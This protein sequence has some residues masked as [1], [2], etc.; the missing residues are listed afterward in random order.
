[1]MADRLPP[2]KARILVCVGPSPACADLIRAA[3]NLATELQ[4]EWF[5][6]Y[7][8][9][10][11]MLRLPEAE[12]NRA[13]YNLR[14]AEQLGAE[15]IT[16]R[17]IRIAA[18]IVNFA[19]RRHITKIVAGKPRGRRWRDF[20]SKS[21]VDELVRLS[22]E[23]DVYVTTGEPGE[24]KEAPVLVQPK[25]IRLPDYEVGLIYVTLATGLCFLMYPYFDLPNLIMVYLLAVMVTAVQ[26]GRGPAI[27][28]ALLSVLAFD[29]CFVPPRWS[30][31]V[32]D[33]KYLVTFVV[34]FL[35]AVVIGHLASLIRRQAE[36]ARL[37]ERQ[38]AAMQALSQQLAGSRGVEKILQVAVQ[39]ISE[40]LGCQVVA[41]LP[42][43]KGRLHVAAGDIASVFHKDIIK[44]LGVAQW[45]YQAG[46]MAGWGTQSMQ[47][48]P[49]LYVPLPGANATLGVLALR[50]RDPEA[51]QWLLPEQLRLRF[52]E[53]LAK[54]VALAL[55]VERLQ[56]AAL[57]AQV[58]AETERLRASLL[59][60][61]T[62]D[63]QT[64]LAAIMGSSSSLLDLQSQLDTQQAQE[65]L[66]NIYDEADRLSRLVNNL[67]DIAMLESGS[68][69]LHQELQPLEEVVGAALNRLEK[70]LA[71]RP[72]TTSL[73]ADLPMVPL[74]SALAEH[75]FINLLENS[76]K[77][78][79]PGSP[80]AIAAVQKDHEIE[81]EVADHGPGFP[82][83]DLE[84]IFEMFDR[85]TKDLGQKGYGLGLSICRAI[86]EAHGG[87][88]W[89]ENRAGGGAAVRFTFPLKDRNHQ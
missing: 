74:D 72:I 34:M 89:A 42:D 30:F 51:E 21:P 63:F 69:K 24:Q 47:D 80:L 1:M 45:T 88:I 15:T 11:K 4:A 18:E 83:E 70:K 59:G 13:V 87:R 5:A 31:T 64:P 76:L 40:I 22:G 67:L 82:P 60:T 79:P 86:V 6:V 55:G 19:R 3:K 66:T 7:V 41:L 37:Q 73:P 38:T 32:E 29:F 2:T 61:V 23:I 78:T 44:E 46:Q 62:H 35:V 53:S 50:P 49:I 26:C 85:G 12:R 71:D 43:D 68:L 48:S 25:P 56:K 58:A 27:L 20:L 54:Q 77:Y 14:L 57:E 65:M 16:L 39:H 9:N 81:V 28:N 8:E 10:P 52:L 33:A 75:I 84:R 17:G 36:A